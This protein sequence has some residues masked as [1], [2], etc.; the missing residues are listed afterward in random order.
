MMDSLIVSI[1]IAI[2]L[3]LAAC[4]KDKA[5]DEPGEEPGGETSALERPGE[6]DRPPSGGKVPSELKPPR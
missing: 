6:L 4:G 5:D 2:T 3:G 1:A